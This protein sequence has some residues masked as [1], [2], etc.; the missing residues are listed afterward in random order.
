MATII[1]TED[2]RTDVPNPKHLQRKIQK[3]RRLEREKSRRQKGCNNRE[4]TRRKIAVLN[5]KVARA[6]RDYHHK[7]ALALIRDNQTVYVESLNI[8]GVVRNKSLARAIADA[9][10]AQFLYAIEEKAEKFG[11]VVDRLP[12]DVRQWTCAL[13]H[14]T[15]D[16]DHNAAKNILAAGRAERLNACGALVSPPIAEAQDDEPGSNPDAA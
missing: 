12:L 14:A 10:W 1:D 9:G 3:L 5:G 8:A 11:H 4:K 6:R 15:H 16:R 13:C 7:L 2:V